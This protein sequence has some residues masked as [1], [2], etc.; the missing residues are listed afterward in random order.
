MI[1]L[2]PR[3][4]QNESA[5]SLF[6]FKYKTSFDIEIFCEAYSP[7]PILYNLLFLKLKIYLKT[8]N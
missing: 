2:M 7:H 1:V 4:H 6:F 5:L 3:L 8:K